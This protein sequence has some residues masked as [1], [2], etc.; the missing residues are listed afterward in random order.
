[1]SLESD[2]KLLSQVPMLS[3]FTE[4]KL[5]LLA[6]SSETRTIR[7]GQRLYATGD[8]ADSA[9]VVSLGKV[10]VFAGSDMEK[11]AAVVG[12]G[13][14]LGELALIVKG[15]RGETAVADGAV[16]YIQIRRSLFHRMLD[17][18]PD[19][20][21]SLHSRI[22]AGLTDTMADLMTVRGRL[23]RLG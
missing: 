3:D 23:D 10:Q 1:M 16:T 20:A 18:Y 12:P 6:F 7:D 17:E 13:H 11:P 4:D 21:R 15:A 14:I 5:R 8:R 22:A 9:F 2:M 19:I